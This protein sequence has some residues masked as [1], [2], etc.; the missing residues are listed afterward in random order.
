M[1]KRF[2]R[3]LSA[4]LTEEKWVAWMARVAEVALD[5]IWPGLREI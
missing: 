3:F 5:G 1:A 4:F 2:G